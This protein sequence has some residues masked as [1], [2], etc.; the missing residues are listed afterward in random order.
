MLV[1]RCSIRSKLGSRL[2]VL[3]FE[4]VGLVLDVSFFDQVFKVLEPM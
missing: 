1:L 2:S 3:W 4:L